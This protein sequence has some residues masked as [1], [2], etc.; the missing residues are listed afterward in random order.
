MS[1][2]DLLRPKWKHSDWRMR[3]AAAKELTDQALLAEIA[4]NDQDVDVRKV[5]VERLTDQVVLAEIIRND[6]FSEV[7]QAGVKRLTDQ[8]LLTHID[9]KS[10]RLNSSHLVI[11]YAVFC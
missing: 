9:R 1:F 10:T 4:R 11:S 6:S 5:A 3:Q 2:A 7:R 8:S